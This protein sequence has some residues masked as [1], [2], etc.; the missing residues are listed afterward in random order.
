[1]TPAFTCLI[2]AHNEATRIASVLAAV[3]GHPLIKS[4][5][6][7]DD[8]SQDGTA[9]IA[10][11]F[12]ITVLR[13]SPNRG[14]SAA[15]A[16]ALARV[17][18]SHVVLLDADLIG[19]TA[20]DLS[21]LIAPVAEARADVALSLR[22]NA[23]L[24]WQWLGVDYITGERVMPMSL[25]TPVLSDIKALPR[26]GLEVFLNSTL[27]QARAS[28]AIVRWRAVSSPSKAHKTG[29]R[30]GVR[31]DLGMMRDILNTVSISTTFAQIAFLRDA[32]QQNGALPIPERLA[33]WIKRLLH[34]RDGHAAHS[35]DTTR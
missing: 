6:V 1:M 31:A 19:L 15:L 20:A 33:L 18:T 17:T 27:Q 2:P 10:S 3:Q 11:A 32:S 5:I 24:L 14:K 26:F 21:C 9:D 28:V 4:V 25:I 35:S 8:G 29:W 13:L 7:I 22:G 23:P 12:G 16:E 30:A 34:I